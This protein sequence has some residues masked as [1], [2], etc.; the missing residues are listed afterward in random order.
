MRHTSY[1]IALFLFFAATAYA[2]PISVPSLPPQPKVLGALLIEVIIVAAVIRNF[3][4]RT[5]RFIAGWYAVN[6]FTFYILL[7]G[8]VMLSGS[9]IIGEVAVFAAEAAAL[10]GVSR[11]SF[12][13]NS[14]SRPVP[15]G[16]AAAASLAGNLA[17]ILAFAVG[18]ALI[19]P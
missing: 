14:D 11:A 13:R 15:L 8:T 12:F 5:A 6:L 2:D 9:T 4:L 18:D 7:Q 19:Y 17:S 10:F 1:I 16:W 3:K